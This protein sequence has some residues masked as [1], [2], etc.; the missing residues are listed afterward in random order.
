MTLWWGKLHKTFHS[1][2]Y[3]AVAKF[4]A[5][6]VAKTVAESRIKFYFSCNLSRNNFGQL[7]GMLHCE[8]FRATCPAT[9]LPK[10]CKTSH[11][12]HFT[13]QQHLSVHLIAC[14]PGHKYDFP[15]LH[16]T[17]TFHVAVCLFCKRS[18]MMSKC[19]KNKKVAHKAIAECV[20]VALT[21]VWCLL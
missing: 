20:S 7:Q 15:M 10:H 13:V 2:I 9:M 18:Q 16:L 12:K 1:V 21:T 14:I 17:N 8:M 4:V 6:Q 11:M 3:P 19:G 5:R